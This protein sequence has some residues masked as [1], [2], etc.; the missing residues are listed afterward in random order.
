MPTRLKK[1]YPSK[2]KQKVVQNAYIIICNAHNSSS[3]FLKQFE[4]IR[5]YREAK[6][7]PT[8]AEQDLLRAMLIFACAGLDSM[9]KQLVRDTLPIIINKDLG[10]S[11]MFIQ[12]TKTSIYK[13]S[14]LNTDLLI[15]AIVKDSPRDVL[16]E[17]LVRELTSG[18]LQS[19][20]E[21]FRVASFFDIRS[22]DLTNNPQD[23]KNIFKIRNQISHEMDIDF[24]QLNRN[25]RPRGRDDMIKCT[26]SIFSLSNIFLDMVDKKL[27]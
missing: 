5:K 14:I 4:D 11:A 1:N 23:F 26:N 13:D 7:T 6:G 12:H 16:I 2:P 8:D 3:S 20:E 10:A 19:V 24:K 22:N 15:R 18:S 9:I 21:I 27:I 17:N 25:R